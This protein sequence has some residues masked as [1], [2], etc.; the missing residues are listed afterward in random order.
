[1]SFEHN[2]FVGMVKKFCS[3]QRKGSGVKHC[4]GLLPRESTHLL[5]TQN[6]VT[7]A[8]HRLER[9][10]HTMFCS[11]LLL[12]QLYPSQ[13]RWSTRA[14]FAAWLKENYIVSCL[15]T[16]FG[17]Y[18]FLLIYWNWQAGCVGRGSRVAS[19]R[20]GFVPD[21]MWDISV[22]GSSHS[23]RN[24]TCPCLELPAIWNSQKNSC[25]WISIYGMEL[26]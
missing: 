8:P 14:P 6:S 15:K 25:N 26:L 1:M 17:N 4:L 2:D 24:A 5:C 16:S 13:K 18:I 12:M 23:T 11:V 20:S 9:C 19:V 21:W 22:V 10:T 3:F 7:C